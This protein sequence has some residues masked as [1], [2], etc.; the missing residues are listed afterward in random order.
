MDF[1]NCTLKQINFDTIDLHKVNGL[2]VKFDNIE[3]NN[4]E[5]TDT[6]FSESRFRRCSFNRCLFKTVKFDKV[7]FDDCAFNNVTYY[8]CTFNPKILNSKFN[9]VKFKW[10]TIETVDKI[11]KNNKFIECLFEAV[12]FRN[13]EFLVER[14]FIHSVKDEFEADNNVHFQYRTMP[15]DTKLNKFENCLSLWTVDSFE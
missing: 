1:E 6:N 8:Q 15:I 11:I 14:S 2:R 10:S 3:F 13:P 4:C 9:N 7:L 12:N 5:I